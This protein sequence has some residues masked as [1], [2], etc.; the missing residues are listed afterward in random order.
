[1]LSD[2]ALRSKGYWGYSPEFLEACRAEL[3]IAADQLPSVTVAEVDCA[4]AGFI[5]L[6]RTGTEVE[7]A[8]LFVDPV[9]IGRSVGAQLLTEALSVA[10]GLGV[11]VVLL[12]A[13][14]GAEGFYAKYGA[15]RIGEVP[16]GSISGRFLP[17]MR[18]RL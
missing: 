8:M 6:E 2:L 9:W 13:D 3:T 7:L 16:S 14:P 15:E 18:F 17:R 11:D 1:M 5:L 12:D 4:V 10:R